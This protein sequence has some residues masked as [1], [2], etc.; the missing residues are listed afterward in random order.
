M[1]SR[2]QQARS[3]V[4]HSLV[5]AASIVMQ[6]A[7]L[8]VCAGVDTA[9][10]QTR[11]VPDTYLATTTAMSP[12]GVTLKIDVTRWSDQSARTA[13]T[14]VLADPPEALS[15]ALSELPTVGVVWLDGSAAGY[16]IKYARREPWGDSGE[17]ITLVTDRPVG[18]YSF[19]PWTVE[20]S[21]ATETYDYSVIELRLEDAKTGIGTMSLATEVVVDAENGSVALASADTAP[22]VLTNV[23]LQ[24]KPYWAQ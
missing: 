18:S 21:Q 17:R 10:A 6:P 19:R 3:F 2:I 1:R 23:S 15:K 12:Q 24:P 22:V 9:L 8:V 4:R 16:A 5:V 20:D 11:P 7:A 13:V 14:S